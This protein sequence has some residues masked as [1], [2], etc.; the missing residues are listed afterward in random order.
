MNHVASDQITFFQT[1]LAAREA[2]HKKFFWQLCESLIGG[3]LHEVCLETR[4][5][6]GFRNIVYLRNLSKR[7][8]AYYDLKTPSTCS[9]L[10]PPAAL[11]CDYELSTPFFCHRPKFTLYWEEFFLKSFKA[12]YHGTLFIRAGLM[13]SEVS[14]DLSNLHN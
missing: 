8:F 1:P 10:F 11:V 13:F 6:A 12:F 4:I 2:T 3:E 9:S 7:L 14:P 5:L